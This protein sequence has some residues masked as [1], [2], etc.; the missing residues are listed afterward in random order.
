[1][2]QFYAQNGTFPDCEGVTCTDNTLCSAV[3]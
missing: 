2:R 1:M 3:N